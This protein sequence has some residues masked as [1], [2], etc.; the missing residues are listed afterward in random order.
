[1]GIMGASDIA[2]PA[3][4]AYSVNGHPA[5]IILPA[6]DASQIIVQAGSS[7]SDRQ[8]TLVREGSDYGRQVTI[9]DF[10][11]TPGDVGQLSVDAGTNVVRFFSSVSQPAHRIELSESGVATSTE[12]LAMAPPMQAGDIDTIRL[13]WNKPVTAEVGI[14][15]GADGSIDQTVVVPNTFGAVYL[16]LLMKH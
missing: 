12:F 8:L 11:L 4:G 9:G 15:H 7:G 13:N 6:P 16:P 1:M 2:Q 5:D 3:A 14:D 10:R